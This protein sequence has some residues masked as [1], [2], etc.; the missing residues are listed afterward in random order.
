MNPEKYTLKLKFFKYIY[1][2]RN[3]Y[4]DLFHF[5]FVKIRSRF[6]TTKVQKS[7]AIQDII[8]VILRATNALR[9]CNFP[10]KCKNNA[11]VKRNDQFLRSKISI[12]SKNSRL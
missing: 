1:I 5:Y 6:S 10:H 8:L 9:I 4:I 2:A 12:N 7:E 11:K 3:Y